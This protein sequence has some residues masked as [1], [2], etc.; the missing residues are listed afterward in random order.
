[1]N[2]LTRNHRE[3]GFT[4]LEILVAL[5]VLGFL[6][7]GLAQ[8]VRFGLRAWDSQSRVLNSQSEADAV[9]RV[10]RRMITLADPGRATIAARIN[11]SRS[12]LSI[13]TSLAGGR[14]PALGEVDAAIGVDSAH[15]LVLRWTPYLNAV[16]LLPSP[17]PDQAVLLNG[18][19]HLD[20]A[21]WGPDASRAEAARGW[22]SQWQGPELPELVRI[23]LVF[24]ADDSRHWPPIIAAPMRA[25]P[26]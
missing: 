4:L 11:G 14:L 23:Q 10:L 3:A 26:G 12:T 22:H 1:M 25:K 19:D 17:A 2:R 18:V 13:V 24:P 7:A 21:Y 5:V 9:E 15:R 8:G 6:L 20:I 16:R